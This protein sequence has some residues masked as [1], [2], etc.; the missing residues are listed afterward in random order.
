MIYSKNL[1]TCVLMLAC[2]SLAGCGLFA[3]DKVSVE[4]DRIAFLDGESLLQP[5]FKPGS[6]KIQLPTPVANPSWS[7]NG[8]NSLH[9]IGHLESADVLQELWDIGFGE[10]SSKRDILLASPVVF[11]K[12]IYTIDAKATVTAFRI[13]DG[14]ELWEHE[15]EP[16]TEG[17]SDASM[18]GAG[19]AVDANQVYVTT[20]FGSVLALNKASGEEVWRYDAGMPFR[21]APTVANNFVFAQTMDNTLLALNAQ[22][23]TEL[24]RYR[25]IQENT[26]LAGGASPAY[27]AELDVVIAAFSNG[28]L[29][30]LKASTGTPL[31][32]VLMVSRK[33]MNSLASINT[34]KANPIIDNGIVYAVGNNHIMMAIDLRTGMPIWERE[35][36]SVNQPWVAGKVIYVLSNEAELMAIEKA[37]GRIVWNTKIPLGEKPSEL[38]GAFA[39]G[40][41][42]TGYRLIVTTSQGYAFAVSPFSG[43]I[44]GFIDL[45]E[46]VSLAPVV[47]ENTVFFTTDDA[48][49]I[50]YQ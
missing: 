21:I 6:V 7:Q 35:I 32:S 4:G 17:D 30:A 19:L 20:G 33:R 18:K 48:D 38:S 50:A 29:R 11:D 10:G 43:K 41:V 46:N 40:P 26:T 47:A 37:S 27:D 49:L 25:S 16:S 15:I 39:T 1:K 9:N 34:I 24:W 8:G 45:D 28:E 44:L 42:L 2:F 36:S 23:G 31:W 3:K 22:N 5:D 13:D 12:T 14:E